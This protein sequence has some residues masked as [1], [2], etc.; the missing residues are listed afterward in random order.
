[1]FFS[2]QVIFSHKL[3]QIISNEKDLNPEAHEEHEEK[4]KM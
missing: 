4:N 3:T 1:L 2:F